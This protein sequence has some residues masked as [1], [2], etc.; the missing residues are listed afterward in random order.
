[1]RVRLESVE[2]FLRGMRRV[3]R[4]ARMRKEVTHDGE[5]VCIVVNEEDTKAFETLPTRHTLV[6]KRLP[7]SRESGRLPQGRFPVAG[8]APRVRRH[9]GFDGNPC[10]RL[11]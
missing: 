5:M 3:Y 8:G 4:R 7:V 1:M 6:P 11:Q 2:T 9:S 10:C